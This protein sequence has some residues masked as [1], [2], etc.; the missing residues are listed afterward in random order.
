MGSP[1]G[2]LL[3]EVAVAEFS[4]CFM[5]SVQDLVSKI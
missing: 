4:A 1:A 2:I 3:A 5:V